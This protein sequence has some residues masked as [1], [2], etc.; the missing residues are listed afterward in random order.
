MKGPIARDW[1]VIRV[2]DLYSLY[3]RDLW[4]STWSTFKTFG[5]F[6]H[7]IHE[8]AYYTWVARDP[9]IST[10]FVKGLIIREWHVIRVKAS[11][12]WSRYKTCRLRVLKLCFQA[13]LPLD[14]FTVYDRHVECPAWAAMDECKTSNWTWMI[15]NCPRSCEVPCK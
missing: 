10:R 15:D 6:K 7:K 8:G 4:R 14:I 3:A 5:L 11:V 2:Q 9:C 1:H 13:I 12:L